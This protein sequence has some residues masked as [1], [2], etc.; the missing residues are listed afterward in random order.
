MKVRVS[1]RQGRSGDGS[2]HRCCQRGWSVA[3]LAFTP[4]N[5]DAIDIVE[6]ATALLLVVTV[7]SVLRGSEDRQ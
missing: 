5:G 3:G 4:S 6:H 2:C 1:A 7:L